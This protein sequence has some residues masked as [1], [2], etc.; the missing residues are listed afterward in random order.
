MR[1]KF[2]L[3]ADMD[4]MVLA[5]RAAKSIYKHPSSKDLVIAFG[6]GETTID[7]YVKKNK[8]SVSVRQLT[9]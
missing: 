5:M 2:I 8:Q 7:F 1:V 4:E 6:D 3:D 9:K